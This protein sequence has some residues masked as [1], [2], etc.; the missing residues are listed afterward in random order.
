MFSSEVSSLKY[1]MNIIKEK[2]TTISKQRNK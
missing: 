2:K 1:E